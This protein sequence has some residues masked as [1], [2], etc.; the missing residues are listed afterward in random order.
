MEEKLLYFKLEQ[1]PNGV[2]LSENYTKHFVDCLQ[3]DEIQDSM[4]ILQ[5]LISVIGEVNRT[6]FFD[7][8][9]RAFGCS[10]E[11]LKNHLSGIA[12][13]TSGDYIFDRG[14]ERFFEE[15]VVEG[16][17]PVKTELSFSVFMDPHGNG[18]LGLTIRYG[19]FK[20]IQKEN[21]FSR[22]HPA[23]ITA[24]AFADTLY[25]ELYFPAIKLLTGD[26]TEKT[27]KAFI[28]RTIDEQF[29][30]IA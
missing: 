26:E 11:A 16:S 1:I 20:H 23:V 13:N 3:Q 24:A 7:V 14:H 4:V 12:E 30:P 15:L 5:G 2:R 8:L 19:V 9:Y 21:S 27:A 28:K 10:S 17:L 25:G 22:R 6:Y 18:N 29:T